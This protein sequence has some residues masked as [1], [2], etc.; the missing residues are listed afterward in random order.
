[1][2]TKLNS[3]ALVGKQVK[4]IEIEANMSKGMFAFSILGVSH[5]FQK[6]L[7]EKIKIILKS[8]NLRLP[9]KRIVINL[10]GSDELIKDK[11]IETSILLA[12]LDLLGYVNVDTKHIFIGEISLSGQ[13]ISLINPY[14]YL[15]NNECNEEYYLVLPYGENIF[16]VESHYINIFYAKNIN[17]IL[18]YIRGRIKLKEAI[19][20]TDIDSNYYITPNN[21]I[22]QQQL[23]RA[24]IIAIAGRHHLLISGVVGCGKSMAIKSMEAIMPRANNKDATIYNSNLFNG[25]FIE[26]APIIQLYTDV[27]LKELTGNKNSVGLYELASD[28]FIQVDEINCLSKSILDNLR[29]TLDI[30]YYG[31]S[32][33][34]GSSHSK[35]SFT[36]LATMNPCPCGNYGSKINKCTCS[37][38]QIESYKKKVTK[39]LLDRF[40]MYIKVDREQGQKE[41][42][43]DLNQLK[44]KIRN[45]WNIQEK[46]YEKSAMKYNGQQS[47]DKMNIYIQLDRKVR[48][49][50][51][52]ISNFYRLSLRQQHNIIRVSRT[53]ADLEGKE[54]IATEH[55]CESLA[56][57]NCMY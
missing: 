9:N 26:K 15:R 13:L 39:P 19:T 1:M 24:L 37:S 17:Q 41:N 25:I 8:L 51:L 44:D 28:A 18:D 29:S 16:K 35:Y 57:Q 10:K 40:Q 22:G 42:Y 38:G 46:R 45:A 33:A 31:K 6:Q 3:M 43:Y 5:Q 52:T 12:L 53:I 4:R 32:S 14:I 47:F 34:Y 2:Y 48:E 50:L 20:F 54:K 55:L 56:Y 23:I 27:K 21:I 11:A 36:L 30:D 7:Y 49:E